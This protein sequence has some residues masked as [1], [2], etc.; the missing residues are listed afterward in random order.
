MQH[1]DTVDVIGDNAGLEN[2][3]TVSNKKRKVEPEVVVFKSK[4]QSVV[5]DFDIKDI[6]STGSKD[7]AHVP[8]ST[9]DGAP[10]QPEFDMKQ[11]R[12]DVQ[13]FGIKG[14][15]GSKKEEAM[16]SFLVKLGAKPPKNKYVNYRE[17][18]EK[19]KKDSEEKRAKKDLDRKMGLKVTPSGKR[20]RVK[21]KDRNDVGEVAGQVGKYRDGVLFVKRRDLVGF[22]KSRKRNK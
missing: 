6:V 5:K 8:N 7:G 3:V 2:L 15:V 4:K 1:T 18:Q 22:N 10:V 20:D 14:F 21:S 11:A 16:T 17:Y 19:V 13:K 9:K 12:F